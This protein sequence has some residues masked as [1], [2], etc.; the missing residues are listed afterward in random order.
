MVHFKI[1][2]L[3][4]LTLKTLG[5]DFKIFHSSINILLYFL[6]KDGKKD[7]PISPLN[8]RGHLGKCSTANTTEFFFLT[9]FKYV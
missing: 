3:S 9:C 8:K 2:H 7:L 5:L 6:F 1:L 4:T